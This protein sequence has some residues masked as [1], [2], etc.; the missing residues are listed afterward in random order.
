MKSFI[1]ELGSVLGAIIILLTVMAIP[2]VIYKIVS[3][4]VTEYKLKGPMTEFKKGGYFWMARISAKETGVINKKEVK[5][6]YN[7]RWVKHTRDFEKTNDSGEK[8]G[9]VEKHCWAWRIKTYRQLKKFNKKFNKIKNMKD[10]KKQAVIY[11]HE[12]TKSFA[13]VIT[14][15]KGNKIKFWGTV[16][17]KSKK[18]CNDAT[19]RLAII[20]DHEAANYKKI[21]D[22]KK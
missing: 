17:A 2:Y 15:V 21:K 20:I 14:T 8:Y 22:I 19:G 11:T 1:E 10:N 5:G 12:N 4:K 3:N 9:N 6:N 18:S 13:S 7:R 16:V